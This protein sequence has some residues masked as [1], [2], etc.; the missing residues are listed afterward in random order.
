MVCRFNKET[1]FTKVIDYENE[2]GADTGFKTSVPKIYP[3][4]HDIS[5][6]SC[7]H[8]C[9]VASVKVP[10][11]LLKIMSERPVQHLEFTLESNIMPEVPNPNAYDGSAVFTIWNIKLTHSDTSPITVDDVITFDDA[12]HPSVASVSDIKLSFR[13][14]TSGPFIM[15][16]TTDYNLNGILIPFIGF[17]KW[18]KYQYHYSMSNVF[19]NVYSECGR[20]Y[21]YWARLRSWGYDYDTDDIIKQY[22][23]ARIYG[24]AK[25][26]LT[27]NEPTFVADIKKIGAS[28]TFNGVFYEKPSRDTDFD[29]ILWWTP[30]HGIFEG[31]YQRYVITGIEGDGPLGIVLQFRGKTILGFDG[32]GDGVGA[33]EVNVQ[34]ESGRYM[35]MISEPGIRAMEDYTKKYPGIIGSYQEEL[36]EPDKKN[37]GGDSDK[38]GTLEMIDIAPKTLVITLKIRNAAKSVSALHEFAASFSIVRKSGDDRWKKV[39]FRSSYDAGYKSSYSEVYNTVSDYLARVSS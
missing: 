38:R 5:T 15:G 10:K 39:S 23:Y 29:K 9:S 17:P 16:R 28:K 37:W 1:I 7:S 2:C 27:Y 21:Y 34:N 26:L 20:D 30:F 36:D 32:T 4:D 18:C 14:R 25:Y 35:T 11:K 22:Q 33:F 6:T 13:A 12:K 24:G 31:Y 3:D 19:K 8:P